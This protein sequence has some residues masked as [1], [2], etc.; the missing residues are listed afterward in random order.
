MKNS[1]Y[2]KLA[3]GM[4]ITFL[5]TDFLNQY[6]RHDQKELIIYNIPNSSVINYIEGEN[7]LLFYNGKKKTLNEIRR[8]TK[9]FWLSKGFRSHTAYKLPESK[10][11]IERAV[12]LHT[13]FIKINGKKIGYICD[14]DLLETLEPTT[15]LELDYL[16]LAENVR[17]SIQEV[18]KYFDFEMVI[19]DSSN[20]YYRREALASE[21]KKEG[22]DYH[23]VQEDGAFRVFFD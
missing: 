17:V 1:R 12:L 19:L 20:S 10:R 11:R 16:I 9:E 7:N 21:L 23:S 3:L 14:K 18:R 15:K 13:N 22:I 5:I 4:I 2:L 8:Y 6:N